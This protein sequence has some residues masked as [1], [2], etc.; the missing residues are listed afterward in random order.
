MAGHWTPAGPIQNL[1]NRAR[2]RPA[3][4][5]RRQIPA[6]PSPPPIPTQLP[7]TQSF[8]ALIQALVP[9][10]T[11]RELSGGR[12]RRPVAPPRFRDEAVDY[13]PHGIALVR[14][15]QRLQHKIAELELDREI[16]ARA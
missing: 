6:C 3:L 11:N 10:A 7:V 8:R 2:P 4:R 16:H 15:R 1:R 12:G 14:I 9:A 5:I 13:P